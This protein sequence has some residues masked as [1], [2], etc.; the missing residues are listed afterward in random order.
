MREWTQVGAEA[1]QELRAEAGATA[2]PAKERGAGGWVK[3]RE[4]TAA[5]NYWKEKCVLACFIYSLLV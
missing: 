1:R 2:A 3:G 5:L 4:V